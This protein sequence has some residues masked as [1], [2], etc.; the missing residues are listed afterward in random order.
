MTSVTA[1]ACGGSSSTAPTAV[2]QTWVANVPLTATDLTAGT[3]A[4]A[5]SGSRMVV[6]YFGWLYSTATTDNKGNLFDTSLQT[7]RTP[8]QFVLGAG[9][10][11]QGWDQGLPG[12]RVGG[13]RRLVIPPALAYGSTGSGSI[14][15]N[16]TLV[17]E[18]RLNDIVISAT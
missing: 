13:V 9:Q 16:A 11:I 1:A 8:F 10:V 12:M 18:V 3:G 7:G 17:F 6:D 2:D 14:P 15:P 5:V 4:E